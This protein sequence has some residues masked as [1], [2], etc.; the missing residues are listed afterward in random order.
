M[1]KGWHSATED[2]SKGCI[3]ELQITRTRGNETACQFCI[4]SILLQYSLLSILKIDS[5]HEE[6]QK[7]K[8]ICHCNC[9]SQACDPEY[10]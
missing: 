5:N 1:L 8:Q 4:S 2:S 7:S 6:H 3:S 9:H 10:R